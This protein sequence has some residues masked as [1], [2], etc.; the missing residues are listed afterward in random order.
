MISLSQRQALLTRY[1]YGQGYIDELSEFL[2]KQ[3][4]STI[5]EC[6]CGDGYIL[7]GL[8]EKGFSGLGIDLDEE[9]V[10]LAQRDHKHPNIEY[11]LMDWLDLDKLGR[12]FDLVM[13]RGGSI[14]S[15]ISWGKSNFDPIEAHRKI[16]ESVKQM[17]QKVRANGLLYIDTI[18][19]QEIDNKGGKVVIKTKHVD[20]EGEIK[21]DWE[22]RIRYMRG[23]GRI[24]S[25][26][27]QE[28]ESYSYLIAPDEL[29]DIIRI[30]QPEAIWRPKLTNER[31]YDIICARKL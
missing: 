14:V 1:F 19:Q 8:G 9:M 2:K 25:L 29:E 4:I 6:G 13:C 27:F 30:H 26:E 16:V 11:A 31:Y 23:G 22:N 12:D 28:G 10:S 18:P 3:H 7:H 17:F 24:G 21:Y 15:V 5:L 20:I